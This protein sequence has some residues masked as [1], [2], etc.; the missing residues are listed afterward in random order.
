MKKKIVLV[1][2][3]IMMLCGCTKN[4]SVVNEET[5][6]QNSYTSNILCKPETEELKNIYENHTD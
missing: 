5:H 4:F 1:V 3:C 6:K 2:L